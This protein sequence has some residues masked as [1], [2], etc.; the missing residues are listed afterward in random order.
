MSS[1]DNKEKVESQEKKIDIL[2]LGMA[3]QIVAEKYGLGST[4]V[5]GHREKYWD[6][7]CNMVIDFYKN[8]LEKIERKTIHII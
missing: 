5:M 3:K 1:K 8:K 6:E 4:L 7:A 2:T